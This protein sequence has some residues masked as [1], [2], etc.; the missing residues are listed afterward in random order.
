MYLLTSTHEEVKAQKVSKQQLLCK[1]YLLDFFSW[2]LCSIIRNIYFF[3]TVCLLFT[4]MLMPN[5]LPTSS[6]LFTV[7]AEWK[8]KSSNSYNI[9]MLSSLFLV[10]N[11]NL[12][13]S[14]FWA[15]G[16]KINSIPV[17]P[18][19]TL[20]DVLRFALNLDE[21]RVHLFSRMYGNVFW[22]TYHNLSIHY[23]LMT[24]KLFPNI[25]W[26]AQKFGRIFGDYRMSWHARGREDVTH[27]D[28][29]ACEAVCL[30]HLGFLQH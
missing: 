9:G 4:I 28:I 30:Y 12:K 2:K 5:L 29:L 6:L 19:Y 20:L 7:A 11:L 14:S 23:Q 27:L 26:Q 8:A 24:L 1:Q 22:A 3:T 17:R 21:G 25:T 18:R 16:K 10:K 15:V 13:H